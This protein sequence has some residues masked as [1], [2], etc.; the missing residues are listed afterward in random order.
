MSYA[1]RTSPE[2]LLLEKLEEVD[3]ALPPA[4]WEQMRADVGMAESLER[5][6]KTMLP[7]VRQ[8]KRMFLRDFVEKAVSMPLKIYPD[9]PPETERQLYRLHLFC[10]QRAIHCPEVRRNPF[11]L[12]FEALREMKT[13]LTGMMISYRLIDPSCPYSWDR[14]FFETNIITDKDAEGRTV[15]KFNRIPPHIVPLAVTEE[16]VTDWLIYRAYD[17]NGIR[18]LMD[19]KNN[20][21]TLPDYQ[22]G[23]APESEFSR[24]ERKMQEQRNREE[25]HKNQ[26]L[27]LE[28]R[29][30]LVRSVAEQ[31]AARMLNTGLSDLEILNQAYNADLNTLVD[32]R[33]SAARYAAHSLPGT[34][35]SL[36]D[37]ACSHFDAAQTLPSRSANPVEFDMT[38]GIS[39]GIVQT[40]CQPFPGMARRQSP[41]NLPR[42]RK[43]C[44]LRTRLL[45]RTRPNPLL[46][47]SRNSRPAPPGKSEPPKRRSHLLWTKSSPAFWKN[48]LPNILKE[49]FPFLLELSKFQSTIHKGKDYFSLAF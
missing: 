23:G 41:P 19:Y 12:G 37:T 39:N 48:N 18:T 40:A 17:N 24:F 10:C 34:A 3:K 21:L 16:L 27:D 25:K 14:K 42:L 33:P 43:L 47:R 2:I 26:E 30:T 11:Q 7:A 38:N 1:E 22:R 20:L 44:P 36:P 31:T 4:L 6:D 29:K 13:A 46:P 45:P 35:H 32:N 49:N 5:A 28:F 8:R 9:V 15:V